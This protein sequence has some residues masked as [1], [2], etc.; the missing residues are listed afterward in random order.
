M[1]RIMRIARELTVVYY[2]YM[3]EYRAELVLWVLSGSLPFIL[4]GIW[5]QAAQTG[6][7]GLTPVQFAR[8]FL[9]AFLA[10][11]FTTVWVIWEFEREIVEGRLSFRLLQPLDPIWHYLASHQSERL[12]RLPFAFVLVGVFFLLYPASFWIPSLGTLALFLFVIT[13]AFILRFLMQ[14]TLAMFAFWTERA[15]ALEQ[16]W[17]LFYLFLSGLIAPLEVFPPAVREFALWTPFPYL[18]HFPASI[19]VGL[20]VDLGRGLLVMGGWSAVFFGIYRWLWRKGLRHYSGM[21]A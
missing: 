12:A 14:Y 11:Q 6:Q 8:Y 15:S 9:G 10:R 1:K 20:P 4:M 17:F 19:L 3:V 2:A 18:V 13:F 7:F 16:F 21:G 5:M